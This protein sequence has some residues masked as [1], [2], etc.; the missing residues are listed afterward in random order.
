MERPPRRDFLRLTSHGSVA[1]A[2]GGTS[3]VMAAC[4]PVD[5]APA[6]VSGLRLRPFLSSR[7]T[8]T[9]GEKVA[10]AGRAAR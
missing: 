8:A 5:L 3:L 6:D 1:I 4:D 10:G 2:I 7:V 9:T